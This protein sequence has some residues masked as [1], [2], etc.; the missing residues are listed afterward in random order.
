MKRLEFLIA[1]I[2]AQLF[3]QSL[4]ATPAPTHLMGP[5]GVIHRLDGVTSRDAS[6]RIKK[7]V[8]LT[9]TLIRGLWAGEIFTTS[10]W[11]GIQG[12]L[13]M[14]YRID[15]GSSDDATNI[16][17]YTCK[18]GW[19]DVGHVIYSALTYKTFMQAL[20]GSHRFIELL[21]DF[22][23]PEDAKL[24]AKVSIELKSGKQRNYDYWAQYFTLKISSNVEA[25]QLSLKRKTPQ[26]KWDGNATSA[27][28]LEDLPSNFY[29]VQLGRRLERKIFVKGV[30]KQFK[31]EFLQMM[32]DFEGVELDNFV[33]VGGKP[34][35]ARD[36]LTRDAEYYVEIAESSPVTRRVSDSTNPRS[37][38]NYTIYHKKTLSHDYVCDR[39][40]R[41]IHIK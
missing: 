31:Q 7:N 38:Y 36:V 1:V 11:I 15:P 16:F 9:E 2:F 19:I 26:K 34:R 18:G 13:S 4:H 30:V 41:P 3:T 21:F 12:L 23:T 33:M 24:F 32:Q 5:S 39:Y 27:Y 6:R 29:G 35:Q 37:P 28:T 8:V 17:V 20:H 40:N 22:L 14:A 25:Y 10:D